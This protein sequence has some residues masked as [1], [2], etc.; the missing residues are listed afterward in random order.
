MMGQKQ[1]RRDC[2]I[3]GRSGLIDILDLPN[4]PLTGLFLSKKPDL[5][6]S[7]G[8]D[9]KL[10]W[11][12]KCGQG[13]L[14]RQI[15]PAILYDC[16]KYTFRTSASINA[17]E[18]TGLFLRFLK[19]LIGNRTL[20]YAIDIGCNDL[21][22]LNATAPFIRRRL[23][24]DPIWSQKEHGNL[25]KGTKV[26]GKTIEEIDFMKDIP[27]KPD[28]VFCR[29][30]IEHIFNPVSI[31]NKLMELADEDT[32]FI[33]ETPSFE[34]LIERC[35]FDQVFHEHLQYFSLASF[36]YIL[37]K[38]GARIIAWIENYHNWGTMLIAFK[39][40]RPKERK[41]RF[42]FKENDIEKRILLFKQQMQNTEKL[43]QGLSKSGI[44]GYG[45]AMMLP[46]L[47]YH[48][49]T[50]FSFFNALLDDDIKK[51]GKYYANLPIRISHSSKI[52]KDTLR[53][54]NVLIT[55]VDNVKPI[56]TKLLSS[57]VKNIIYPFN[58][59]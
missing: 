56:M 20:N 59:V 6:I 11:C 37:N 31:I 14:L 40:A 28:I 44:Y 15:N 8:I 43:M 17:K 49:K 5:P 13:Q 45:A 4:L 42:R 54:S 1:T 55:A 53:N 26:L 27:P 3:C 50:D 34:T 23:G 21:Y 9:Q 58:I 36:E 57:R 18:G 16:K 10:L 33:F 47:G 51:D 7:R 12:P 41:F 52:N 29:H 38:G 22:L 25:P 2:S 19:T 32:L 46:V 30:T 24:I 35:R 48:L 39:K